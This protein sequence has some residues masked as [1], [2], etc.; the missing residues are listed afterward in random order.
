MPLSDDAL[1]FTCGINSYPETPTYNWYNNDFDVTEC[2]NYKMMASDFTYHI[3]IIQRHN[4]IIKFIYPNMKSQNIIS[5]AILELP[6]NGNRI[7][8]LYW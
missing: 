7:H 6:H 1:E 3:D 2:H 5:N 8:L 4:N